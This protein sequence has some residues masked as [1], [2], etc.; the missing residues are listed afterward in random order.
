MTLEELRRE[1]AGGHVRPAYLLGGEEPLLRDDALASIRETVLAG[2]PVDFNL[3]RMEGRS[4]AP[5][6]LLDAVGTLPVMAARR[7][8]VLDEPVGLRGGDKALADALPE[9][10][11]G[12]LEQE[13]TVLVVR[14]TRPD[15]RSRWVK[16]FAEPAASVDCDPPRRAREL[17]SFVRDEARRQGVELESGAAELLAERVGPQLLMLRQEV[18]KAALFAGEGEP[19]TRAHIRAGSIDVA[20]E[21]IWDLTDAIGE[22]RTADAVTLLARLLGGGAPAPV[23]LGTLASHFRKLAR[24]R[25]GGRVAGAPFMV[26]KLDSQARRYTPGRLLV[27]LREIHRSDTALKGAGSLPPDI[28]LERLVIGLAG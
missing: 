23:V 13:Q 18:A 2:A 15:R 4:T 9:I 26:R 16:A 21:P 25:S 5:A 11:R 1:L 12:L 28:V 6:A 7:L 20:D 14:A 27:C 17:A 22:G 8:V 19:I 24:V 10:V 3:D